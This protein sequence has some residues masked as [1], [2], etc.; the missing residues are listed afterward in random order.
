[1]NWIAAFRQSCPVPGMRDSHQLCCRTTSTRPNSFAWTQ[2]ENVLLLFGQV[3][4]F[5]EFDV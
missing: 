5:A 2:A 3:N 4:F 1:M